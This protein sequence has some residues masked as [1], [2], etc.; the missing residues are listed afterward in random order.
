VRGKGKL[1]LFA[2]GNWEK[3][4]R[5]A[6]TNGLEKLKERRGGGGMEGRSLRWKRENKKGLRLI[7][8]SQTPRFES[9]EQ[10]N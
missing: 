5:E 7:L 9:L 4:Q 3:G 8:K 6:T 2:E 1:F 10:R